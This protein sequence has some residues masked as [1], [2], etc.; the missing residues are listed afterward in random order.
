M[1]LCDHVAL[2]EGKL[3]INGGGWSTTGPAPS[4]SGIAVFLEVPWVEANR[5]I[6]FKLKLLHEDGEPFTQLTPV[7]AMMPVEITAT[8]EV[9]RPPGVPE[10]TALP[11]PLPINLPPLPLAPGQG[12]YWQAE[13]NQQSK[14]EWRLSFRTR[15]LSLPSHDPS[16][17]TSLPDF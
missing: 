9:G 8:L 15:P 1:L 17:P 10:G 12:F 3:Y 14:E 11:V 16:D 4:P 7:G 2:A 6:E 5:K 13:I